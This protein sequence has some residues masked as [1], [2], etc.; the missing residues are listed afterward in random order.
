MNMLSK[1]AQKLK[2]INTKVNIL[3]S[4]SII[5]CT[6][7]NSHLIRRFSDLIKYSLQEFA[8]NA[9]YTSGIQ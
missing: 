7:I 1:L 5:C 9:F 4:T 6:L 8:S 3:Q 2:T